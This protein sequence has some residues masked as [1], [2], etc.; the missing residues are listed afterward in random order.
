MTVD[1]SSA[2]ATTFVLFRLM[3]SRSF[4]MIGSICPSDAAGLSRDTPVTSHVMYVGNRKAEFKASN[5]LGKMTVEEPAQMAVKG[6]TF[7]AQY[8]LP[9][10]PVPALEQTLNRYLDTCRP[11][12]DDEQF[13]ATSEIVQKFKEKEGP[14]L[15]KLLEKRA[16]K[17]TNWLSD[18]WKSVA[19]L[20]I[21]L[22][23][24]V[25]N[26]GFYLP[27]QNF[28]G[29]QG[30]IDFTSRMIAGLLDYKIMLDEQTLSVDTMGGKPLCMV[31]HYQLLN[32]CRVPGL[33]KDKHVHISPNDSDQPHHITLIHNNHIFSMDVYSSQGKPLSIAQLR[34]QIQFCVDQS[35][36][37]AA[38]V[39][40]LT[41]MD[42]S[43]WGKAYHEMVKDKT[44][45]ASLENIQRS[46][47]AVS[48]DGPL[49]QPTEGS[50]VDMAAAISLHGGGSKVFSGNRWF[51]K[52]LQFYIGEDG[53]VL[54]NYEHTTAEGPPLVCIMDHILNFLEKKKDPFL[55][56]PNVLPPKQLNFNLSEKVEQ[57]IRCGL[58]DIDS[59]VKDIMIRSFFFKDYG[60]NFIKKAKM[61]PDAYIQVALQLAYY[62]VYKQP[63][64][65]Y[66]SGSLRCFQL[67]RTDTIRSCSSA[68]LAFSKAMGDSSVDP[69]TKVDLLRKAV[70]SHR[71]YTDYTISG[72]AVDRHLLGLKLTALESGRDI[73]ELFTDLAFKESTNF[74]LSTSQVAI[75]REAFLYF[76]PVVQD[77]YGLCYN[78]QEEQIIVCI[79]SFNNSPETSSEKLMDSVS[80]SLR[81]MQK[82][83]E[84]QMQTKL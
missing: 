63:C 13:K 82:L 51:D 80:Q 46:I 4:N 52:T 84:T 45:K 60:K 66:E 31:Q 6:R 72:Q 39:G 44:N 18:W 70:Q 75:Q 59:I 65:T 50:D 67:G 9:R 36:M 26:P 58:E 22:P 29:K 77:G 35:K 79:T 71:Q 16:T 57:T 2:C 42:R 83:L 37:A 54:A 81:D 28:R 3:L 8:N 1:M 27:R 15:Q 12:L 56:A 48:L 61:S 62:R 19:Y 49:P 68:S 14:E 55:D 20:D 73:P 76:V 38:P 30:Q 41:T 25:L 78:P 43:S 74:R 11:L 24:V 34:A 10:L 33:K 47:L 64:A 5:L 69:A 17:H 21:R 32:A 40:I 53:Y 7:S 23:L